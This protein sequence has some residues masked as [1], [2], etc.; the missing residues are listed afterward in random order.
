MNEKDGYTLLGYFLG[1]FTVLCILGI[2]VLSGASVDDVSEVEYDARYAVVVDDILFWCKSK[3]GIN[4]SFVTLKNCNDTQSN[5]VVVRNYES[6]TV[7]PIE[8]VE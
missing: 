2:S 1:I 4:S 6:I 8:R 5:K 7:T 3:P